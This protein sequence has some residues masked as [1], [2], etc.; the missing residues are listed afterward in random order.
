MRNNLDCAFC[1]LA[2]ERVVMSNEYAFAVRDLFP[3]TDL[4]TLVIPRRHVSSYFDLTET[5]LLQ[6]R[7]LLV[8]A[9]QDIMQQD[10]SVAGFNIGVNIGETAGQTVMH[11]HIHLIPRRTGDVAEPRGGI[12][13]LIPGKGSY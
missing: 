2:E 6:C 10:H 9:K 8:L 5:E 1:V 11:A 13:H 3:V 4:H 12:R 7:D